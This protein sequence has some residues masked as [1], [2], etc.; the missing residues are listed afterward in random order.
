MSHFT[1]AQS[2]RLN[3][4]MESSL[5]HRPQSSRDTVSLSRVLRQS[6]HAVRRSLGA[7]GEFMIEASEELNRARA[8]SEKY[9]RSYW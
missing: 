1:L 4:T 3:D 8:Q 2:S 5:L 6:W 9:T 7:F